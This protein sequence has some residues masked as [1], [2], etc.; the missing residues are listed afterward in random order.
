M[1]LFK[2]NILLPYK[3]LSKLYPFFKEITIFDVS[4]LWYH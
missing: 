2:K 3:S 1:L 4:Q